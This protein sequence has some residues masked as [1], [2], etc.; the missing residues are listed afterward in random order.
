[1]KIIIDPIIQLQK[2]MTG[3]PVLMA[4]GNKPAIE[5]MMPT[6]YHISLVGIRLKKLIIE[7]TSI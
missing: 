5:G 1:M 2:R 7:A 3:P 4:K 6:A